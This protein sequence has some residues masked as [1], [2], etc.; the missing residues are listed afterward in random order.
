MVFLTDLHQQ[1]LRFVQLEKRYSHNTVESYRNDL[2]QWESYLQTTYQ[3]NQIGGIQSFMVR[4]WFAAMRG[5]GVSARSIHRKRSALQGSVKFAMQQGWLKKSYLEGVVLPKVE[6][7]LPSYVE[8]EPLEFLIKK[9][10]FEEGWNGISKRLFIYMLYATGMRVSE[11][12]LLKLENVDLHYSLIRV[13]GKGNKERMIPLA[14]ELMKEVKDFLESREQ[15]NSSNEFFFVKES[16]VPFTRQYAYSFVK[17][18]LTFVTT[19]KKKSPHVLRH[20]FATH[21]LNNGAEL[22]AVKELLGHSS[23]AATQVYT[24]NSIEQLKKVFQQAHPK[25]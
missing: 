15:I 25:A 7:R 5:E 14:S 8:K 22:N 12:V 1:F 23:L 10:E 20:S 4:S 16:G 21:M 24:H 6:K 18:Y 3:I 19:V 9:A 17:H 13:L 2:D 11:L